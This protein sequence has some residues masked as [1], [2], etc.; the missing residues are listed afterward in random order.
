MT[1]R[2]IREEDIFFERTHRKKRTKKIIDGCETEKTV[3]V[4][5]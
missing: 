2:L 1:K 5:F 4:T 3:L